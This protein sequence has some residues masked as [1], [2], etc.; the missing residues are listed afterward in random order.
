MFVLDTV[1]GAARC[2]VLQFVRVQDYDTVVTHQ[3]V[4]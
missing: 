2:D 1:V 3:V 4:W